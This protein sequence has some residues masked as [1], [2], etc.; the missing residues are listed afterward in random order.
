MLVK[1]FEARSVKE[2]IEMV[3]T[4]LGPDAIILNVR[5]NKKTYGLVGEGSVEITA[6]ASE[7]SIR[8]RQVMEASMTKER[9]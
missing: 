3:K 8:K 6:A 1:K 5:D 4:Q 7:E 2:A 9:I